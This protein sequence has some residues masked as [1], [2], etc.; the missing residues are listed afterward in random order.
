MH[1][2]REYLAAGYVLGGLDVEEIAQAEQL[3]QDDAGFAREVADFEETMALVAADDDQ[4]APSEEAARAILAIPGPRPSA[5]AAAQD[6]AP[7]TEP[8]PDADRRPRARR[9]GPALY[10]ALAASLLLL[11]CAVL[12]GT[13]LR[14]HAENEQLRETVAGLGSE[15][16]H[17]E[18]LLG[19]PDLEARHV[20]VGDGSSVTVSFSVAEQLILV[21]PHDM[22][23]PA[24]GED[25][26]MWIIDQDGAHDAG[27][28]T[29]EGP[30]VI[31]GRPFSADAAFGITVEPEGGSEEPTSD[32]LVVAEL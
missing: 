32:P 11:L 30:A 20:E 28:M 15:Q 3:L 5:D 10:F 18:Q 14:I 24:E 27:L 12:G 31:S 4:V 6:V 21:T 16:E 25:L 8:R 1:A 7:A 22:D 2:D 29:A 17:S 19:A 23:D 26:Q 13:A 9:N